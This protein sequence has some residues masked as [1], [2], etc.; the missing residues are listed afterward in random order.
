MGWPLAGRIREG[1][2]LTMLR[3]KSIQEQCLFCC[4][5]DVQWKRQRGLRLY[6]LP[7]PY[8]I[9]RWF[10]GSHADKGSGQW[11]SSLKAGTARGAY[12]K[13][14]NPK[15]GVTTKDTPTAPRSYLR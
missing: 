10:C 12:A 1:H 11:Q 5:N 3:V 9:D 2:T 14:H 13:L 4:G 15:T 8:R 6:H 7:L